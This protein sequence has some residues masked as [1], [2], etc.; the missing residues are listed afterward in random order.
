MT[1]PAE[2]DVLARTLWGEAR[3]ETDQGLHAVA[4]VIRNRARMGGWWGSTITTVCRKPWQ[5]S[6]WNENDPNSV[7]LRGEKAIPHVDYQRC[8]RAAAS[9]LEDKVA[10]PTGGATHYYS[11]SMAKP[12]A[13]VKGAVMAA[14][15]G[16]HLFYRGV[17]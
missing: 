4:W 12:P 10:D 9:V 6:C 1:T 11:T 5:F 14:K 7:Y 15:I 17:K 3:G 2:L 13:W 16:R 8:A